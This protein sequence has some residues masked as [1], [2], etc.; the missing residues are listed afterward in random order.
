M[1]LAVTAQRIQKNEKKRRRMRLRLDNFKLPPNCFGK[2]NSEKHVDAPISQ[3]HWNH[4]AQAVAEYKTVKENFKQ[5]TNTTTTTTS[6]RSGSSK[7]IEEKKAELFG[8]ERPIDIID[9]DS[10]DS[11]SSLPDLSAPTTTSPQQDA[12]TVGDDFDGTENE[13]QELLQAL[14]MSLEDSPQFASAIASTTPPPTPEVVLKSLDTSSQK[15]RQT[16]EAKKRDY[17]SPLKRRH[18]RVYRNRLLRKLHDYSNTKYWFELMG[19]RAISR[20]IGGTSS[21][22]T[23]STWTQAVAEVRSELQTKL[24]KIKK[25]GREMGIAGGIADSDDSDE[26]EEELDS[27]SRWSSEQV[28]RPWTDARAFVR[29]DYLA[30][31]CHVNKVSKNKT[32]DLT[33]PLKLRIAYRLANPLDKPLS[34]SFINDLTKCFVNVA[35]LAKVPCSPNQVVS[36]VIASNNNRDDVDNSDDDNDNVLDFSDIFRSLL[37]KGEEAADA[38]SLNKQKSNIL[39]WVLDSCPLEK[40]TDEGTVVFRSWFQCVLLTLDF[41]SALVPNLMIRFVN[42]IHRYNNG[43]CKK[44]VRIWDERFYLNQLEVKKFKGEETMRAGFSDHL[45]KLTP[46]TFFANTLSCEHN[47]SSPPTPSIEKDLTT[48]VCDCCCCQTQR[49]LALQ[50]GTPVENLAKQHHKTGWLRLTKDVSKSYPE[51]NILVLVF[52]NALDTLAQHRKN[53]REYFE[54][55]SH[56]HVP[57]LHYLR[58]LYKGK[59]EGVDKETMSEALKVGAEEMKG[60]LNQETLLH[61]NRTICSKLFQLFGLSGLNYHLSSSS[62][63]SYERS[64]LTPMYEILTGPKEQQKRTRANLLDQEDIFDTF[65]N[66]AGVL[67]SH[68]ETKEIASQLFTTDPDFR[69]SAI[70]V[71][72]FKYKV[73]AVN[74]MRYKHHNYQQ[75]ESVGGEANRAKSMVT[76]ETWMETNAPNQIYGEQWQKQTLGYISVRPQCFQKYQVLRNDFG[77]CIQQLPAKNFEIDAVV[78]QHTTATSERRKLRNKKEQDNRPDPTTIFKNCIHGADNETCVSYHTSDRTAFAFSHV[79]VWNLDAVVEDRCNQNSDLTLTC[80]A[81]FNMFADVFPAQTQSCAEICAIL[82]HPVIAAAYRFLKEKKNGFWRNYLPNITNKI[83]CGTNQIYNTGLVLLDRRKVNQEYR[84]PRNFCKFSTTA[85]VMSLNRHGG[86]LKNFSTLDMVFV[87]RLVHRD[88]ENDHNLRRFAAEVFK[89]SFIKKEVKSYHGTFRYGTRPVNKS[90]STNGLLRKDNHPIERELDNIL[91]PIAPFNDSDIAGTLLLSEREDA[92]ANEDC[93]SQVELHRN[94]MNYGRNTKTMEL[95]LLI[96]GSVVMDKATD[97]ETVKEIEREV[98]KELRETT[99]NLGYYPDCRNTVLLTLKSDVADM[100]V[101]RVVLEDFE[102]FFGQLFSLVVPC[103][104]LSSNRDAVVMLCLQILANKKM[105]DEKLYRLAKLYLERLEADA[106]LKDILFHPD[107]PSPRTRTRRSDYLHDPS[108]TLAIRPSYI[109]LSR[110]PRGAKYLEDELL[111]LYPQCQPTVIPVTATTIPHKLTTTSTTKIYLMQSPDLALDLYKKLDRKFAKN[112]SHERLSGVIIFEEE[113]VDDDG[114]LLMSLVSQV[115]LY[116]MKDDLTNFPEP[117]RLPQIRGYFSKNIATRNLL[118]NFIQ[119]HQPNSFSRSHF[120]SVLRSKIKS[121]GFGMFL[122][123]KEENGAQNL[124]QIKKGVIQSYSK[125][126]CEDCQDCDTKLRTTFQEKTSQKKKKKKRMNVLSQLENVG[127]YFHGEGRVALFELWLGLCTFFTIGSVFDEDKKKMEKTRSRPPVLR[128][129]VCEHDASFQRTLRNLLKT[130]IEQSI[131]NLSNAS[132]PACMVQPNPWHRLCTDDAATIEEPCQIKKCVELKTDIARENFNALNNWRLNMK[133]TAK[134]HRLRALFSSEWH[135]DIRAVNITNLFLNQSRPLKKLLKTTRCDKHGRNPILD[136]SLEEVYRRACSSFVWG[137]QTI[138][139]MNME[140]QIRETKTRPI[141]NDLVKPKDDAMW[142]SPLN[143][144]HPTLS[145]LL[146]Q[147]GDML[148]V[149]EEGK[150]QLANQNCFGCSDWLLATPFYKPC[151]CCCE[152]FILHN[153]QGGNIHCNLYECD[154]CMLRSMRTQHPVQLGYPFNRSRIKCSVCDDHPCKVRRPVFRYIFGI[155]KGNI[156]G[157]EIFENKKKSDQENFT[158]LKVCRG[159]LS[160]KNMEDI[161]VACKPWIGRNFLHPNMG[162]AEMAPHN[163]VLTKQVVDNNTTAR[164]YAVGL[165]QNLLKVSW[166]LHCVNKTRG[167]VIEQQ[168]EEGY[169]RDPHYVEYEAGVMASIFGFHR[170]LRCDGVH[171]G[172]KGFKKWTTNELIRMDTEAAA[173]SHMVTRSWGLDRNMKSRNSKMFSQETSLGV[174]RPRPVNDMLLM[175]KL[176][177]I[178]C[179]PGEKLLDL[180]F[181][182]TFTGICRECIG[183]MVRVGQ[184]LATELASFPYRL[185][186][187]QRHSLTVVKHTAFG[188]FE[189][190]SADSET[191]IPLSDYADRIVMSFGRNCP[192]RPDLYRKNYRFK[193]WDELNTVRCA[194]LTNNTTTKKETANRTFLLLSR[195]IDNGMSQ[196]ILSVFGKLVQVNAPD[197]VYFVNLLDIVNDLCKKSRL[198]L[199]GKVLLDE[200]LEKIEKISFIPNTLNQQMGYLK[201]VFCPVC[202]EPG[203]G[204]NA[205]LEPKLSE[206]EKKSTLK[207]RCGRIQKASTII[208]PSTENSKSSKNSSSASALTSPLLSST[209]TAATST[210]SQ[211]GLDLPMLNNHT[212]QVT[213][214]SKENDATKR[215]VRTAPMIYMEDSKLI[216]EGVTPLLQSCSWNVIT[217]SIGLLHCNDCKRVVCGVCP[218]NRLRNQPCDEKMKMN[219]SPNKSEGRDDDILDFGGSESEGEKRDREK[220]DRFNPPAHFNN[221]LCIS[222]IFSRPTNL[223]G[224]LETLK[225]LGDRHGMYFTDIHYVTLMCI[226]CPELSESAAAAA[227]HKDESFGEWKR[228]NQQRPKMKLTEQ[229]QPDLDMCSIKELRVWREVVSRATSANKKLSK[230]TTK[231]RTNLL[232]WKSLNILL[233]FFTVRKTRVFL[234]PTGTFFDPVDCFIKTNKQLLSKVT[235]KFS[236]QILGDDLRNAITNRFNVMASSVNR[237]SPLKGLKYPLGVDIMRNPATMCFSTINVGNILSSKSQY[238]QLEIASAASK[239]PYPN[240]S[241]MSEQSSAIHGVF[242]RS[243]S[244]SPHLNF[245]AAPKGVER[246]HLFVKHTNT[247]INSDSSDYEEEGAAS[248]KWK[249]KKRESDRKRQR[250]ER[251]V[252]EL[253]DEQ[254]DE[255]SKSLDQRRRRRRRNAFI[256]HKGVSVGYCYKIPPCPMSTSP[257]P[258]QELIP[259]DGELSW[260]TEEDKILERHHIQYMES[261]GN[262]SS[263]IF[264]SSCI[265]ASELD[266]E[267][268]ADEPEEIEKEEEEVHDEKVVAAGFDDEDSDESMSLLAPVQSSPP[269]TPPPHPPTLTEEERRRE[270]LRRKRQTH[271]IVFDSEDDDDTPQPSTYTLFLEDIRRN[272]VFRGDLRR[273]RAG[274]DFLNSFYSIPSKTVTRSMMRAVPLER[275]CIPNLFSVSS[276]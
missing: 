124:L 167:V 116:K 60:F 201:P 166:N 9:L 78:H 86:S 156:G 128:E 168:G 176:H 75:S 35:S 61:N 85:E 191:P 31:N 213:E 209:A 256:Y 195:N 119:H 34:G 70:G 77:N 264:S 138:P 240:Y 45:G 76:V 208:P 14:K 230:S 79:N 267:E 232:S 228:S 80:G 145:T 71:E 67:Q 207:A 255:Q 186:D 146:F 102:K 58:F 244:E 158:L 46:G 105:M 83:N 161:D 192:T 198:D 239:T 250:R 189:L 13:R 42:R 226:I 41:L 52:E 109:M 51:S 26:E 3:K 248:G 148:N 74:S 261:D 65:D 271:G 5:S 110:K 229:F 2:R 118:Q 241:Y 275:L 154:S 157:L 252:A 251:M 29:R 98:A 210:T 59:E 215:S 39:F 27:N 40:V 175:F 1:A 10:V 253:L 188:P 11:D 222:N 73:H 266:D 235:H 62:E 38:A 21:S 211:E 95:A 100:D 36:S 274:E 263:C 193:V 172:R 81:L 233:N 63:T 276:E 234:L 25:I 50:K 87:A 187:R 170:M 12:I 151:F 149:I 159:C 206:R 260:K 120:L 130:E 17:L 20:I 122:N 247:N 125:R 7:T 197:Q 47:S 177:G 164:M 265:S 205:R 8:L 155:K 238:D 242:D 258:H 69:R 49:K 254:E 111:K 202:S 28:P 97:P 101:S 223:N 194:Y 93:M 4:L 114:F 231:N 140:L 221:I 84:I 137:E 32:R 30:F 162:F 249:R 179:T 142:D 37:K 182:S 143:S 94:M 72:E 115:P 64:L 273:R 126:S 141:K 203:I 16:A 54:P 90:P 199:Y 181:N 99:S 53:T 163:S 245:S 121:V 6:S 200:M 220:R 173:Q 217:T 152:D 89:A 133:Q 132:N 216:K 268:E 218:T 246:L 259:Y 144:V 103:I 107:S 48:D 44:T 15:F 237:L 272:R 68:R 113:F 136:F 183:D 160:F 169:I 106:L 262:N 171:V 196:S 135:T 104:N 108:P 82:Q 43:L 91:R 165:M 227:V 184:S 219:C 123:I 270:P 129:E 57:N 134:T 150:N 18:C 225:H 131:N 153:Y 236:T 56:E 33:L 178:Q 224:V 212:N 269:T 66:R 96:L 185:H 92:L 139:T 214:K 24:S 174:K 112:D 190:F 204:L 88:K 147:T 55:F 243:N 257:T 180:Y 23:K 127:Y 117:K 19:D 22:S